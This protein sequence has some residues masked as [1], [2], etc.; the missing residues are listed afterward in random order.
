MTVLKGLGVSQLVVGRENERQVLDDFLAAARRGDGG[1]VVVHGD[2]GIGKTA[3]LDYAVASAKEFDIFRTVGN[4]AEMELPYAALHQLCRLGMA[5]VERLPELQRNA[6][7][8]VFGR[9]HG[10]APDHVLVGTALVGLFSALSSKRP[11]LCVV[12]DAQWLDTSSAQ[13]IAFAARRT[14]KDA[15]AFL[16]GARTPTEEVR[17][18]PELTLCGLSDQDARTLLATVLPDRLD[19]RVVDRLVAEARGNPL[20][21]LELPQ[22]LTPSQLAGGFGLPVSV[23]LAGAIEESYRR[24]LAKLPLPCRRLLLVAAADPTGDPGIV[25][26]AA[27]RLAIA[28]EAAEDVE[29]KGLVDF[30]EGVVF[31]HPLVRSAVYNM[32]APKDRRETHRALAEATDRALD[33]D[34]RAWHRAQATS[35]PNEDVAAELEASAERAQARGGFPAAAAFLERSVALTVDPAR[36]A[37]RSLRAAQSKRLAG[38]LESASGLAAIAGRGPLDDLQRAQLDALLGQIAF[39]ENRGNDAAPLML[40]AASR[41]ERIDASL[42]RDA[43]LDALAASLFA[44]DASAPEV[45]A[46]ARARPSPGEPLRASELL[47]EGLALLITEGYKSATPVLK[48]AMT[49]FRSNDIGVD[50]RLQWSWLA[51]AVA[52]VIWDYESWDAL[53]ARQEHLAR[54]AGALTVLPVTL[55]TRAGVCLFAGE[56]TEA[57][58]LVDQVQVVT[59]ACDNKRLL[60]GSLLLAAFGGNEREARQLIAAITKDSLARGQGLAVAIALWATALLWNGLGRYEEAFRAAVEALKAPNDLWYAGWAT[61]ELVEAASRIGNTEKTKPALEK[62]LDSTD[63]SGTRWALGL[64]ARCQALLYE[65]DQAEAL[66]QQSIEWLLPTRLRFDLARTRLLYGEWLRREQRPRD[67]RVQLRTAHELFSEFGMDGFAQRARAE[68]QAAGDNVR[69]HIAETRFDLTPQESRISELVAKGATNQDIAAQMFISPAT[70]EYHLCHV[71]RKLGVRSRTQLAHTL[72]RVE[73]GRNG[74]SF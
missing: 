21:L 25:W 16:F 36:R 14:S 8:V 59:D 66:Y 68:L 27:D 18:L 37:V 28:K 53:T 56:M 32:A 44:G 47:L 46:A 60:R 64:Q 29:D 69:V 73:A 35:R 67:A 42:A 40:K 4:E 20:A 15:I 5:E 71:Y 45:A 1:A 74:N 13:L 50:E 22:G 39:A 6:L 24:R 17:R 52:G 38:A 49:A 9:R 41:L 3:L 54:D 23:T 57:A 48:Q 58:H 19:D 72:L 26:R 51:G 12:D 33:P 62:L 31:R 34:R 2:P 10:A 11:L 43:Q 55:S 63:A 30:S 61:V 70:V 65:G 7:E